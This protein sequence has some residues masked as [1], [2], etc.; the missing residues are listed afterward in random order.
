MGKI[1]LSCVAQSRIILPTGLFAAFLQTRRLGCW[2]QPLTKARRR[3][4]CAWKLVF[5]CE[6]LSQKRIGEVTLDAEYNY[7]L[8]HHLLQSRCGW[9]TGAAVLDLQT[10]LSF[11]D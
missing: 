1:L 9:T 4:S 11:A 7:A 10:P 6:A 2:I 3:S 5:S 8:E